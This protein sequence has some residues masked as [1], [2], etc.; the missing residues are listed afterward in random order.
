MT[1]RSGAKS[2]IGKCSAHS[3]SIFSIQWKRKVHFLNGCQEHLWYF[4]L[5]CLQSANV[6]SC[7]KLQ[8]IIPLFSLIFHFFAIYA[9][10]KR[11]LKNAQTFQVSSSI[12]SSSKREW[13]TTKLETDWCELLKKS[14]QKILFPPS[15]LNILSQNNWLPSL[16]T[17]H[18]VFKSER[19]R[20]NDVSRVFI[21][22]APNKS[23]FP[24]PHREIFIH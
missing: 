16:L 22:I 5:S 2:A 24:H 10:W 4:K 18:S 11:K 20:E 21:P 6:C 15:E 13:M 14:T 1:R 12:S 3:H 7:F 9:S 17:A 8:E 19:E 23:H